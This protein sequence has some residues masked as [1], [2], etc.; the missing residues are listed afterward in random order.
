MFSD[1]GPLISARLITKGHAEVCFVNKKDAKTAIDK[2]DRRELDGIPMTLKM[3]EKP[4][5]IRYGDYFKFRTMY[6]FNNGPQRHKDRTLSLIAM[7]NYQ[8]R[9][10]A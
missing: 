7:L 2:Y 6:D 9:R 3:I 10:P 8:L 1:I 4:G 5:A